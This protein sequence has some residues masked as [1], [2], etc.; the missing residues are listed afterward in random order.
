M[1]SLTTPGIKQNQ[2]LLSPREHNPKIEDN[3]HK[4]ARLIDLHESI[5]RRNKLSPG[6]LMQQAVNEKRKKE[7]NAV[8]PFAVLAEAA[9]KY[10]PEQDRRS[11]QQLIQFLKTADPQNMYQLTEVSKKANKVY[12]SFNF[13]LDEESQEAWTYQLDLD[14][15][16]NQ[17]QVALYK[18]RD[19]LIEQKPE[20][21][22]QFGVENQFKKLH[23]DAEVPTCLVNTQQQLGIVLFGGKVENDCGRFAT[24]LFYELRTRALLNLQ[25]EGVPGKQMLNHPDISGI[26]ADVLT[27]FKSATFPYPHHAKTSIGSHNGKIYS[28]EAHKGKPFML[29][30]EL[31]EFDSIDSYLEKSDVY[32]EKRSTKSLLS[33]L[34]PMDLSR[35]SDED[36][37]KFLKAFMNEVNEPLGRR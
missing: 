31:R 26:R 28:L 15:W 3:R 20:R 17:L 11:V 35:Y 18:R 4:T 10:I 27:Y 25:K 33:E 37:L 7:H 36:M 19:E 30:P 1:Q 5:S 24:K 21:L 6:E 9:L 29:A 14:T 13:R 23:P 22:L 32:I 16:R 8:K 34:G 2:Q 12:E